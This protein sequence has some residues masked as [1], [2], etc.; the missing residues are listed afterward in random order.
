MR[1]KRNTVEGVTEMTTKIYAN[2]YNLETDK[3]VEIGGTKD[4]IKKDL[5]D[6]ERI[7]MINEKCTVDI[8]AVDERGKRVNLMDF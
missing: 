3:Y 1:E 6:M 8:Y 7:G 4:S 2:I 5:K